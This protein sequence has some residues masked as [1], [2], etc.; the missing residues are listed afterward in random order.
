LFSIELG[1]YEL[2]LPD[3]EMWATIRRPVR[4]LV[5]EQ[6]LPF[7]NEIANRLATRFGWDVATTPGRHGAYHDHHA[8]LAQAIRPFLHEV[9]AARR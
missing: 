9:S 7:F 1:T 5:S 6:S 3:N 2:S 4:L 8:E